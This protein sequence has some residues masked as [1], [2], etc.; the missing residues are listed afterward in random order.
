MWW[1]KSLN[2]VTLLDWVFEFIGIT[3]DMVFGHVRHSPM[4]H[5][6]HM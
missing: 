2:Q 4:N 3:I 1:V 5:E 6:D